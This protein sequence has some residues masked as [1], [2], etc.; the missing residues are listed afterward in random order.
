VVRLEVKE[1]FD[2]YWDSKHL[3]WFDRYDDFL[4]I[5]NLD[6]FERLAEVKHQRVLVI[7]IGNTTDRDRFSSLT[8]RIIAVDLSRDGLRHLPNFTR[9]QMDGHQLGFKPATFDIVFFRTILLHC[10]HVRMVREVRRVLRKGGYLFWIEPLK[11]N[12]FLWLFRCIISPGKLTVM[13]YMTF[14][15]FEALRATFGKV[16]HREC[17]LFT[18]LLL[19]VFILFPPLRKLIFFLQRVEMH[20]VDA[21]PWLRRWCWISYGYAGAKKCS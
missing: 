4:Q 10:Q 14:D 20:M 21:V 12:P 7:G 8:S 16:W 2:R 5:V 15:E 11:H 18:V 3:R 1:F 6:L 13:N 9:I 17:Y 19:P